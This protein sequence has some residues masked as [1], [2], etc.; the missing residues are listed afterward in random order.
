MKVLEY[1]SQLT[2]IP[3]CSHRSEKLKKFL[4]DFA[5]MHGYDVQ[6]DAA[7]N[8]LASKGAP[9]L[10]L[11]AHYDMVCVGKAP[12]IVLH[13]EDGWWYAQ[14]SSLGADNGIAIAMMMA[15]MEEG[16]VCEYLFT[17]D[18]EVGL[19]GANALQFPLQSRYMLNL[20]S[21]DEAEV[22]IGCA[23]GVDI[24]AQKIYETVSCEQDFY[25]ITVSKLP[26]GHSGVEIHK[27]IPN[28]IKLFADYCA[29][30]EVLVSFIEGGERINAIPVHCRAIVASRKELSSVRDIDVKK[31]SGTYPVIRESENLLKLLREIPHG[32][33]SW[34]EKLDIPDKSLNLATISLKEGICKI[35]TSARAMDQEGLQSAEEKIKTLFTSFGYSVKSEGKYPAWEPEVNDFSKIVCE[36]MQE[37]Y[38]SCAYKAIHAGL[39]CA[40]ISDLYPDIKIASIGPNIRSPHSSHESV[41]IASVKK[42]YQ[43]VKKIV[44]AIS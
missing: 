1:F 21:E 3:H 30:R 7:G 28:A 19:I 15:L 27:D 44:N 39:E 8:I 18:E 42:I 41:E 12:D 35:A 33:L 36:K 31:I 32:V 23:G 43:V 10:C 20:D 25:E 14:D 5:R 6:T 13:E 16:V 29:D 4:I 2:Q 24:F 9:K 26:G 40:V 34:N 22:Y 38:A 37:V 11:Q 17:A